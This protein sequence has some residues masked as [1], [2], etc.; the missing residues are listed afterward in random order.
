MIPRNILR[1]SLARPLFN[2]LGHRQAR[3]LSTEVFLPVN[4]FK[5]DETQMREMVETL[6]ETLLG[7]KL[8]KWTKPAPWI[9]ILSR[10]YLIKALWG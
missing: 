10:R 8:Q 7:R 4:T 2:N 9:L 6:H 5:E 1:K 3:A